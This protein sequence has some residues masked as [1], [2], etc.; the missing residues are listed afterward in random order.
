MKRATSKARG[1]GRTQPLAPVKI[2][3]WEDIKQ[4]S[5]LS[6]ARREQVTEVARKGIVAEILTGDLR[7]VRELTGKTQ[8]QI[9]EVLQRTQSELSRFERREDYKL[10]TLRRYIE[11][12]GGEL[13][14]VAK[15]GDRTV[16]L[17]AV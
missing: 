5:K 7:A 17:R 16:R 4:G 13:E 14:V 12:L 3:R 11:A 15:F 6:P 8:V 2:K 9:A 1:R 10:S